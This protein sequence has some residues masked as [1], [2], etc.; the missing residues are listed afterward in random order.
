MALM[1][2][3]AIAFGKDKKLADDAKNN[4]YGYSCVLTDGLKTVFNTYRFEDWEGGSWLAVYPT[5]LSTSG[6]C[7]ERDARKMTEV[8]NHLY[9]LL[10][11]I[12]SYRYAIVGVEVEEFRLE[13]EIQCLEDVNYDG[14]V[15]SKE[16][17]NKIGNPEDFI[18]FQKNYY[19]RPY[20]GELYEE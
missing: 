8:A 16:I 3:L 2:E 19:W 6:I 7:S 18:P 15:L 10:R 13:S 1:F 14:V 17:W 9:D 20:N 12:P 5:G 11:N 4:F